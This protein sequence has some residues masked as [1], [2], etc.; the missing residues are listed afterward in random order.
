MPVLQL[1]I[2]KGSLQQ[3]TI[4]MFKKAGYKIMVNSRSYYPSILGPL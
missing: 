2:P 3:T 1:G 4:E